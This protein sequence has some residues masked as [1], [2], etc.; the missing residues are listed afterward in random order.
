MNPS[1]PLFP[2]AYIASSAFSA[3]GT[4]GGA[5]LIPRA[6]TLDNFRT[7]LSG[8]VVVAGE[9]ATDYITPIHLV[10]IDN[11]EV[12]GGPDNVFDPDNPYVL[13]PHLCAAAAESPLTVADLLPVD[14]AVLLVPGSAQASRRCH[15]R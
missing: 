8:E 12:D 5:S 6:V 9:A 10:T 1:M 2:V 14:G 7:I 13:G 11:I 3:D 15:S 4:L